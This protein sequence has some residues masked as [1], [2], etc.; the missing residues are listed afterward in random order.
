MLNVIMLNDDVMSGIL[1]NVIMPNDVMLS[2][3]MLNVIM[4]NDVMLSG[5]APSRQG[6]DVGLK[7]CFQENLDK[8]SRKLLQNS[9]DRGCFSC[10]KVA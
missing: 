2:G 7:N 6:V 10:K 3:I 4:P 1:M 8:N 9:Y 5:V